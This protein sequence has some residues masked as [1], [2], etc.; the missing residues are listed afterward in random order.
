[1]AKNEEERRK[2]ENERLKKE[3]E[4]NM[5]RG[6]VNQFARS[7]TVTQF[8]VWNSDKPIVLDVFSLAATFVDSLGNT[9]DVKDIAVA[10]R[11]FNVILRSESNTVRVHK[12][13]ENMIIGMANGRLVYISFTEY[14]ALGITA[15]TRSQVF[16]MNILSNQNNNYGYIQSLISK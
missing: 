16:K 14:Q 10:S 4:R 6:K 8:G 3:Q 5:E 9:L 11:S 15:N 13:G 7:I 2:K 12:N 1:R